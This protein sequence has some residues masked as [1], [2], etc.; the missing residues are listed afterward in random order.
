[1]EVTTNNYFSPLPYC[2]KNIQLFKLQ[3]KKYIILT[4]SL[5]QSTFIFTLTLYLVGLQPLTFVDVAQWDIYS[6]NKKIK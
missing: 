4:Q 3:I 5:T 1:M 6:K 2:C